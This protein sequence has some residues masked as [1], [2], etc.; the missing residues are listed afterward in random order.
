MARSK[1]DYNK[2]I[3][4]C[5]ELLKRLKVDIKESMDRYQTNNIP[6]SLDNHSRMQNDIVR[7]RRELMNLSKMLDN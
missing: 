3:N 4:F 2:Q 5:E 1:L 7:L 6:Y